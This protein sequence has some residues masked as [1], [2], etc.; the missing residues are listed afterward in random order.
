MN[1]TMLMLQK[2]QGWRWLATACLCAALLASPAHEAL[3]RTLEQVR[4]LGAISMCANPDA[5]PYAASK[6]DLPGFQIEIGRAIAEG[7]GVP[8]N[9]DWI[10]PRRRAKV[11]NCDMMLDTVNDPEV[12]KGRLLLSRPYQ[13]TGIGLGLGPNGANVNGF[14]DIQKGQKSQKI[15]VMIGS[16]SSVVLGK[17][18]F[19][20]SPYAFQSDML[21]DLIKGELFGI[22][23]SPATMSYYIKQH[24]EAALRLVNAYDSEPDLAWTVSVGLR[25]S[26]A[27][28]QDMVNSVLE[29]LLADGTIT[30]IYAK[31]G[32]EHRLP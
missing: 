6:G 4:S 27:A 1:P 7:L 3:A 29:K 2:S 13:K 21:E 15:G 32:L 14:E 12:Y 9:V 17:R 10:F 8:L 31:Y 28:L 18:G 30:R 11:V 26:D 23:V 24:P 25:Q 20:T 22:A 16:L 5:L 19:Y